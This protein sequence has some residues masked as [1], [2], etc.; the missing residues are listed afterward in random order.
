MDKD[1]TI[2]L[3]AIAIPFMLGL[4]FLLPNLMIPQGTYQGSYNERQTLPHDVP[5]TGTT[6]IQDQI[7]NFLI[8]QSYDS[9][10]YQS[11]TY[12][13]PYTESM[14]STYNNEYVSTS[15]SVSALQK[16]DAGTLSIM[17]DYDQY[18]PD[19]YVITSG[20][21]QSGD[22]TS[23]YDIDTNRLTYTPHNALSTISQS[24]TITMNNPLR[25]TMTPYIWQYE[26]N[27]IN[28]GGS[29]TYTY[30]MQE[31]SY[32]TRV[33]A[34]DY[35][36]DKTNLIITPDETDVT[37]L[38]SLDG[39]LYN[40]YS[41]N[42]NFGTRTW[43]QYG[44]SGLGPDAPGNRVSDVNGKAKLHLRIR[45]DSS[46]S[47]FLVGRSYSGYMSG[48]EISI[49]IPYGEINLAYSPSWIDYW[50]D[51]DDPSPQ[52]SIYVSF[53]FSSEHGYNFAG[54]IYIE[55]LEVVW[56]IRYIEQAS[57]SVNY[58]VNNLE[59]TD[60]VLLSRTGEAFNIYNNLPRYQCTWVFN[61][62]QLPHYSASYPIVLNIYN[63]QFLKIIINNADY[64]TVFPTYLPTDLV[65]N[66]VYSSHTYSFDSSIELKVEHAHTDHIWLKPI[67][68]Q[69]TTLRVD[70]IYNSGAPTT[71]TIDANPSTYDVLDY[72]DKDIDHITVIAETISSIVNP[73]PYWSITHQMDMMQIYCFVA[74][75]VRIVNFM[76]NNDDI[77]IDSEVRVNFRYQSSM[78]FSL[79]INS[80]LYSMPIHASQTTEYITET[81]S[82]VMDIQIRFTTSA[83]TDSIIIDD[84]FIDVTYNPFQSVSLQNFLYHTNG[85]DYYQT[86][87]PT[88]D[89]VV[90][91][92]WVITLEY[93]ISSSQLTYYV[94][95]T[96]LY[97]PDQL[98]SYQV[99]MEPAISFT[100]SCF[101]IT[102]PSV[103]VIPASSTLNLNYG[104]DYQIMFHLNDAQ[105]LYYSLFFDGEL[106]TGHILQ[107]ISNYHEDVSVWI[108]EVGGPFTGSHTFECVVTDGVEDYDSGLT[109][110][111]F[112]TNTPSIPTILTASQTV[113]AESLGI[114]WTT[115]TYADYYNVYYNNIF[116]HTAASIT[117]TI[118]IPYN[119]HIDVQV[120]GKNDWA[121][122]S[123]SAVCA[124]KFINKIPSSSQFSTINQTVTDLDAFSLVW[125]YSDFAEGYY[126]LW[127]NSV[128]Q[129][130]QDN[131]VTTS[132]GFFPTVNGFWEVTI[133]AYNRFGNAT[134]S[135]K[136]G[137]TLALLPTKP[138][139]ITANQTVINNA[140]ITLIWHPST[141]AHN[142]TLFLN[143]T[144]YAKTTDTTYQYTFPTV[145]AELN[146]TLLASNELGNSSLSIPC[147]II[148][149]IYVPFAFTIITTNHTNNG[150]F[151][152]TWNPSQYALSYIVYG[153]N[154]AISYVSNTSAFIQLTSQG[155]WQIKVGAINNYGITYSNEIMLNVTF[156]LPSRPIFLNNSQTL[157]FNIFSLNYTSNNMT[158]YHIFINGVLNRT[159]ID[160][161]TIFSMPFL[162]AIYEF[163]V[164]AENSYGNS[165]NSEILMIKI[166]VIV[167]IT[168]IITDAHSHVN[169]SIS[170]QW[171]LV[172]FTDIYYVLVNHQ[173]KIATTNLQ[174]IF[175]YPAMNHTYIF[176]IIAQNIAGNSSESDFVSVDIIV[177]L[178]NQPILTTPSQTIKGP[179]ILTLNWGIVSNAKGYYVFDNTSIRDQTTLNY[180][181][182]TLA[183]GTHVLSVIAYNDIGNSSAAI[184]TINVTSG[185]NE[186][187]KTPS[188]SSNMATWG[189]IPIGAAGITI[190]GVIIYEIR[191]E[192][193]LNT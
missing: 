133:I 147:K 31:Q 27:V 80:H 68:P 178:P 58:I 135:N 10:I 118:T 49:D 93:G 141:N 165:T 59:Y 5:L 160:N 157:G 151:N 187:I 70:T 191:K 116:N 52:N 18:D 85:I 61:V 134:T 115:S 14:D 98:L 106:I 23:L 99:V 90:N 15:G 25:N 78:A 53:D 39:N 67:Y 182:L 41:E 143:G 96:D 122:S 146:F 144:E 142:Y 105:S 55:T 77:A 37:N 54:P 50:F 30:N 186:T 112:A 79:Y 150:T 128:T 46:G 65:I 163:I 156:W 152:L 36:L 139:F 121:E 76:V 190:L 137:I 83:E 120:T 4:A 64:L 11:I 183:I 1:F 188:A 130:I 57:A 126:I 181:T 114:E 129:N 167:P 87:T 94:H 177:Y 173:T 148:S 124:L 103:T 162:N 175:D 95:S 132:D 174:T 43:V 60:E 117:D 69:W 88:L 193:I 123:K 86:I 89:N 131:Q 92:D 48:G 66:I 75:H 62:N 102:L 3:I 26:N 172:D 29:L 32:Q 71:T 179:L 42:N 91:N 110:V 81:F 109:T 45:S 136:L 72:V 73:Y 192:N 166:I 51:I 13:N 16:G 100:A 108:H 169:N 184:I 56:N 145:S 33:L 6:L 140:S 153:N 170:V 63:T 19:S 185:E 38:K 101:T 28:P 155:I 84:L 7:E 164:I 125:T 34:T 8:R 149:T 127:N 138:I 159:T 74:A 12:A 171:D 180:S 113:F 176:T 20:T 97:I 24:R 154:S 9:N 2:K 161:W 47:H 104:D 82:S 168:P 22:L 158:L 40:S 107:P 21:Y 189:W 44:T 17:P 35:F 111:N 119:A